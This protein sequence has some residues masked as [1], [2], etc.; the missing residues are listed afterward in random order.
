M[1]KLHSYYLFVLSAGELLKLGISDGMRGKFY[2]LWLLFWSIYQC[3]E[4]GSYH[5]FIYIWRHGRLQCQK[6][7]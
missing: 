3:S 6:S 7:Y 1:Y 5:L 2:R 4:H